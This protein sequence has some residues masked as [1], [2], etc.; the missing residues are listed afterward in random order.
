M[1]KMAS[2]TL[3]FSLLFAVAASQVSAHDGHQQSINTDWMEPRSESGAYWLGLLLGY[4]TGHYYAGDTNKGLSYL[5]WD[6]GLSI[7]AFALQAPISLSNT[8]DQDDNPYIDLDKDAETALQISVGVVVLGL[9]VERFIQAS[10]AESTAKATNQQ[11]EILRPKILPLIS[12]GGSG[13]MGLQ[14]VWFF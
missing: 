7:L 8:L 14:L 3:V 13:S 10:S 9:I 4:G 5:Y 11:L 1:K 2:V 12:D 6:I